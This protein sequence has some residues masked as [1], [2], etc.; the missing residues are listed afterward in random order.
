MVDDV[1]RAASDEAIMALRSAKVD[2]TELEDW[3]NTIVESQ[4][5]DR[6]ISE[7]RLEGFAYGEAV[8]AEVRSRLADA[9]FPDSPTRLIEV[10]LNVKCS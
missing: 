7:S 8:R 4:S 10:H 3:K 5:G 2:G 1:P 6:E 9:G